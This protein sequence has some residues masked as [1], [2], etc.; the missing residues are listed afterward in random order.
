MEDASFDNNGA[1]PG[2]RQL[3]RS[4]FTTSFLH[5]QTTTQEILSLEI[6]RLEYLRRWGLTCC[7]LRVLIRDL[8]RLLGGSGGTTSTRTP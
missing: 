2:R 5:L 8:G 3:P 4:M 7:G 1:I 6:S